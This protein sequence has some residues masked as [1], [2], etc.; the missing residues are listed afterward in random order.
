MRRAS[1]AAFILLLL[2]G[3]LVPGASAMPRDAALDRGL[4]N[5]DAYAYS[6]KMRSLTA[7]ADEAQAM[8]E[9]ALDNAPDSPGFYFTLAVSKLPSVV[10]S[11]D[12]F[13][14][15]VKA[16]SRSFWWRL[17]LIALLLEAALL[18]AAIALTVAALLRLPRDLPLITHDINEHKALLLLPLLIMPLAFLGPLS[19][20]GGVLFLVCM[21]MK[22]TNKLVAYIALLFIALAPLWTDFVGK[23]AS[24][25]NPTVR[26]LVDVSEGRDNM[27][28]LSTLGGSEDFPSMFSYA[29]ALKREG[30]GEE[31]VELLQGLI[32]ENSDHRLYN[33]LGN[34]YVAIGRRDLAKAAY[35]KAIEQ[36]K[37]VTT[38]Y[39]L[40]Q[41]YRD[42]LDYENGE[43]YFN[44]AQEM[45]KSQVSVYTTR[46]A[47]HYNR[48]V[49]DETLTFAEINRAA[50]LSEATNSGRGFP[51]GTVLPAGVAAG[52]LVLFMIMGKIMPSSAFRC[53]NCGKVAC[54][55]CAENEKMCMDCQMKLAQDDDASPQARVKRMLQANQQKEKQMTIIRVLSFAPPGIA[56]TYSGRLFAGVLYMWLFGFGVAVLVLNPFM[57]TGLA[58]N[59]HG[60]LWLVM[61][62]LLLLIYYVSIITINRRLDRGWL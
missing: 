40:A 55:D 13:I 1:L 41:I 32:E 27:L 59:S 26:A 9:E 37:S 33:N 20:V 47:K 56:Q 45:S 25:T 42:E 7:G 23:T 19:F 11:F 3:F 36:G 35:L 18:S 51:R 22:R 31:A 6:L 54:I 53:K 8:L 14:E 15:G 44:Q 60:W 62:P 24:L 10:R 48:M 43:K 2:L 52:L 4:S 5:D 29:I 28:A 39:N 17:S 34:A 58:G 16:Y 46:T 38:L 50:W 12:L 61:A 30:R 21:Y 49:F 57:S